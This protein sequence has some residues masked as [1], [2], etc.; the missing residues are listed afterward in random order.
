MSNLEN[1]EM[2]SD[3]IFDAIKIIVREIPNAVFGGSIALSGVGLINRPISD[4]D[5]FFTLQESLTKNNF[6]KITKSD[7][8]SE[9]VTNTNGVEIQR[10]G[11][12]I[13]NVK[14]CCFKV[15]DE[16]LQHSKHTFIRDGESITI[17]LQNVNY[18]IDAKRSY[19]PRN[20]KHKKDLEQIETSLKDILNENL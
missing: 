14:V 17:L 2:L 13:G 16:E 6:I 19:S 3:E 18:A 20:S 12:K 10:T 7:I 5:L 15:S 4:I 9:T 1:K 11:A 8:T